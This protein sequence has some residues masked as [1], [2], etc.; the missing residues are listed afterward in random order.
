MFSKHLESLKSF[1]AKDNQ[2]DRAT[3]SE[4]ALKLVEVR[5]GIKPSIIIINGFLSKKS[6]DVSDWLEVV[7]ELYPHNE[8]LHARWNAGDLTSIA[9]DSGLVPERTEMLATKS[10]QMSVFDALSTATGQWKNAFHESNQVGVELAAE[11]EGNESLHG[12]IL[13]GH[14]LGAR[15]VRHTLAELD[16]PVVSVAYLLAGAVSSEQG[17][18]LEIFKKHP[19]TKF[20]NCMSQ[21]DL[22]LKNAYPMGCLFDHEPAGLTP[23]CEENCINLLNLDVTEYADGHSDFKQKKIGQY[24]KKELVKLDQSKIEE[25][26][27]S[28]V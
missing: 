25:R 4:P 28:L 17:E 10:I 11:L 16:K 14:S 24:L 13:M 19:E 27:L 18:W 6:E 5:K 2:T 8:V 3:R 12:A 9:T 26:S 21:N 15:V 22:V 7:D 1:L 20:I 23:L